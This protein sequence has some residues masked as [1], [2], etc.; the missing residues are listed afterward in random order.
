[1]KDSI[2]LIRM[3]VLTVLLAAS[4]AACN[5]D[6]PAFVGGGTGIDN[7]TEIPG[8][9][10]DILGIFTYN[11]GTEVESNVWAENMSLGLFLTKDSLINPYEND[12]DTYSN[13]KCVYTKVGW[14][15]QPDD[16][17]LSDRPAVIYAYA[18]YQ[19]DVDPFFIPVECVSGDYYMYGTHLE[20]QTSVRKGANVAKIHMKHMLAL[21]DFRIRKL[22]WDGK[23]ELQNVVIRRKGYTAVDSMSRAVVADSTNAL[24][25]EGTFDLQSGILTNT[26][27]GQYES[28]RLSAVV[29]EDF[30]TS[31]RFT[32]TVMPMNVEK[33]MVEIAF[34]LNG[35]EKSIVLREG[36]DWTAGARSIIN[37]TFTGEGFEI[38]ESIKPW[39]DI[40]QDI[41][42]NT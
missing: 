29:T 37:L 35:I 18:P 2:V 31:A 20:P 41:I 15:T 25:I 28:G 19:K 6:D 9:A 8:L 26:G 23:L 40:E 16:I 7:N 33:D 12:R 10:T 38:E 42:V 22:D 39:V 4:V 34:T 14:R 17:K 24:P 3:T 36:K 21:I 27:Y 30:N 11:G 13:I 5:N 32:Q 1:M